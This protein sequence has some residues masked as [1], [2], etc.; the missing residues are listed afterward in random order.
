MA[1]GEPD[2]PGEPAPSVSVPPPQSGEPTASEA[3]GR[4]RRLPATALD[5][6]RDAE[7]LEMIERLEALGYASGSEPAGA[8]TGLEIFAAGQT[9]PGYT[10]ITSG[11]APEAFL[12]DPSGQI[13]HRWHKAYRDIWPEHAARDPDAQTTFWRRAQLL[14]NG[15]VL[16]LFDGR[17]IVELDPQSNLVWARRNG[18]HHDLAV[19]ADGKIYV[20]TRK[21]QMLPALNPEKPILEDFIEVLDSRGEQVQRLSLLE[22]FEQSDFASLTRPSYDR[23]GDLFHTN[24]VSLLDGRIAERLP[25]FRAGNLLLSSFALHWLAV[26]DL[27]TESI[28][29]VRQGRFRNQHDPQILENGN[30]LLFDNRGENVGSHHASAVLELD[31]VTGRE[32]WAYRGNPETPFY[33]SSCGAAQRLANG[34]TLISESD[35]G[36]AFEVTRQG[37]IVWQYRNPHRAGSEGELIA[38]LFEAWRL[39]PDFPLDWL[40][41]PAP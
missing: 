34:N 26:V 40:A 22:A 19:G 38:T 23:G 16:A 35:R 41:T 25:A 37:E 29:W 5:P 11:H 30:L 3:P 6:R 18:A 14:P 9:E 32:Q 28:V 17:G 33:S 8:P 20:L 15:H 36:R 7:Q 12:I 31:P 21:A 24:T 2:G 10:F 4:W 27:E 39:P 13:V 1:C